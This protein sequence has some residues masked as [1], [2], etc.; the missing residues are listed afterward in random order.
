M[1][2]ELAYVTLQTGTEGMAKQRNGWHGPVV[3]VLF[4]VGVLAGCAS[5]PGAA[6][7]GGPTAISGAP[8]VAGAEVPP[9]RLRVIGTNDFHGHLLPTRP[10]WAEGR[11]VGGAA[12][13]AAYFAEAR[14]GIDAPTVLLDGG[15]V[16][17]GTPISNLT[18]GRATIE[19]YNAV[20][21]TAAAVGNHEFDWTAEV[22]AERIAESEFA[23]LS[24]NIF[25]A[26]TDTL[27]AWGRATETVR[28]PGCAAGP[29]ACDSVQVGIVG[30]ITRSTPVAAMP[31]YVAPF[32]F[33]DEAEAIDRWVPRLR[34]EGADFVIVVAHEG[35]VCPAGAG[36]D[37]RGR[38]IDVVARLAH[39]PDLIV[40]GHSH[41]LLDIAPSGVPLTQSREY[42]YNISVIDLE[43]VSGDSVAVHVRAQPVTWA[44]EVEPDPA[45]AAL[46]D[47]YVREMAPTLYEV[48]TVLD[49][50]LVRDAP[51]IPLGNLIADAQRR[52]TGTQVA[53]MNNGGIR[54]E[55]QAGEVQ[56][57][58][59]FR[60]QP[61]GNTLVTM[62]LSGEQLLAAF[63]H[64]LRGGRAGAHISGARM[65]YRPDAEP[66]HRLVSATL[67]SGEPIL[68]G[69]TYR[70]TANNFLV[71]GG[72]GFWMLAEG[73]AKDYTGI[74]DLEA[75]IDHLR[76]LPRP[77]PHPE[78]GRI[79]PID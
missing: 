66:N 23:W 54:T 67:D 58:D 29:P 37:C 65:T 22:F 44:D 20:G 70:V 56:Y 57:Q 17:Q 64:V 25:V 49:Q 73:S 78:I 71:D 35:A 62:T 43:R 75:L 1:Q 18:R 50:P 28:L 7:A 36:D 11:E 79:T 53:I 4:A 30:V 41:Q 61:F 12:V 47:R 55:L 2:D 32:D 40:S 21:Y 69:G 33:G 51:E 26:G 42:G 68:P 24:A 59:L 14:A 16:M 39:P 6:P 3:G 38:M 9:K 19:F 10:P 60:V 5:S 45:V 31:S 63:E 8:V 15:D 34:E 74:L 76:S 77:L 72:D 48:V 13:L 46:I 52:T 27:P